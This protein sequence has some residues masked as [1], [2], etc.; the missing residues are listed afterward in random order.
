MNH[1]VQLSEFQRG[2][3]RRLAAFLS[4]LPAET[5]DMEVFCDISRVTAQKHCGTVGCAVGY[6]PNAGIACLTGESWV[7]YGDRVFVSFKSDDWDWMF[8]GQWSGIDNTP[9]GAAKRIL[10]Y[11]RRG[12]P[13]DWS[14]QM[15]G[16][17]PLSYLNEPLDDPDPV[18]LP[19]SQY[20]GAALESAGALAK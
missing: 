13:F 12:I 20:V 2:N 7:Q 18:T 19:L 5:F 10:F 6:G 9:V 11:T 16:D 15:T 1:E 8:N 17:A 4:R 3:L 14:E